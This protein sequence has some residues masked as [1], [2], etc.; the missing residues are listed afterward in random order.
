MRSHVARVEQKLFN[1]SAPKSTANPR[2]RRGVAKMND[3]F[4]PFD[5]RRCR[6]LVRAIVNLLMTTNTVFLENGRFHIGQRVAAIAFELDDQ[7]FP[8]LHIA[9]RRID[10]R[11]DRRSRSGN[12]CRCGGGVASLFGALTLETQADPRPLAGEMSAEFWRGS[13]GGGSPNWWI[14]PLSR[15]ELLRQYKSIV[16]AEVGIILEFEGGERHPVALTYL[17][18]PSWRR[19]RLEFY[20]QYNTAPG[21]MRLVVF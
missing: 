13:G 1:E 10:I 20:V 15:V 21:D 7:R 5:E 17:W 19:W 18:D 8:A 2:K 6:C 16:Y 3:V 4:L 14:A 9:K 11:H 12:R